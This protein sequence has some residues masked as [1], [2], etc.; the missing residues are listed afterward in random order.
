MKLNALA[1]SVLLFALSSCQVSAQREES[2][3]EKMQREMME[4]QKQMM[5]EIEKGFSMRNFNF[6]GDSTG[7]FFHFDTTFSGGGHASDFFRLSP[8]GS[9][10]TSE[11]GQI[12]DFFRQ[13]FNMA[14]GFGR[15][16]QSPEGSEY[17]DENGTED[18]LPEEKLRLK[19]E[20]EKG[21]KPAAEKPKPTRK[22]TRI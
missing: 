10:S 16:G 15:N 1:I 2:D 13:F 19:E 11:F 20:A 22:T 3:F 18:L 6:E 4:A 17:L 8:F 12:D 5:K 14:E 21:E 7:F 9:D